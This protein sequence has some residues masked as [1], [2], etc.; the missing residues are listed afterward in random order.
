MKT[1]TETKKLYGGTVD[2]TFY[3]TS[4]RYKKTGEKSYLTSVTAVTG[5]VDK[6]QFLIPWA[7]GLAANYLRAFIETA[8]EEYIHKTSLSSA[9]DEAARQHT[10]KKEEASDKGSQVHAY[11]E[12]FT[13]AVLQGHAPTAPEVEDDDVKRGITAFLEWYAGHHVQFIASEMLVYSRKHNYVGTL[14]AVAMVDGKKYIIDYKTSKRI[15][16]EYTL[17]VA[18]YGIAYEE[19]HGAVDGYIILR[20]DKETGELEKH[21]IDKKADIKEAKS[22]F[23]AALKLK[24]WLKFA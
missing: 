22:V 24:Q 14:D 18:G 13:Q 5:V 10:I 15:Y 20:F 23:L 7:V 12:Q 4:H 6:S 2:I 3:P 17:Q 19:E 1:L 21:T 9:V 11:A 16:Q 8:S